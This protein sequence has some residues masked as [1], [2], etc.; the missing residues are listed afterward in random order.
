MWDVERVR[1]LF[2]FSARFIDVTLQVV[3][4]TNLLLKDGVA[5]DI[6]VGHVEGASVR[7]LNRTWGFASTNRLDEIH[8]IAE[9]AY[10]GSKEGREIKFKAGEAVVDE[11]RVKPAKDPRNVTLEEKKELLHQAEDELRDY[12]EVVSSS[13]AYAESRSA[14]LYMNSEG[15]SVQTEYPRTAFSA[16]VFAKKNS[17]LQGASERLG[18]VGGFEH[19]DGHL[20][21]A[22]EAAMKAVRLLNAGEAP[23]GDFQVI[24]DPRLDGVFMHEAV[25][26]AVEADHVLHGESVLENKLGERLASEEVTLYDDPTLRNSFGFYFYDSE[27][28][29][30]RKKAVIEKGLLKTYLHS[31]E[32]AAAFGQESTGNARSQ[33]FDYPPIVRMS[34]TYLGAGNYRFEEMLEDINF[35]VYLKGSKGGEVD[36]ARGVFQFNAEE[37]MLIEKG[38]LTKPVRDVSLSGKTLE[39]LQRIDAVGRDFAVHIGYCGKASQMVPVGD[40]GPH[41]RTRATVGGTQSWTRSKR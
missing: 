7:M 27:G 24:L 21:A 32:T 26:H 9:R 31:R 14:L 2:E 25:G 39:I 17:K 41:V 37:G 15:S 10:K 18:G 28:T 13:I 40:G 20:E 38:E 36:T 19:V 5:K 29:R 4:T 34:N 1:K 3:E 30:A 11:V 23:K 6:V 8:K 12:K 33:S 35:G 22:N 16:Y